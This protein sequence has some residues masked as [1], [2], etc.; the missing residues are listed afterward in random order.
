[1]EKVESVQY[2]AALAITGTWKGTN[3]LKLYEELGWESLSDR[4][5]SN[6]ILQVHKIID[7]KTPSYLH[8]KLPPNRHPF[9]TTVFR[10]I[11][12][13]KD[14]YKKSF[15]PDAISSWNGIITH[16]EYF[17]MRDTL[18]KHLL[19]FFRAKPK[20]IFNLHDPEGLRHIFQLKGKF[21]HFQ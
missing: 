8:A 17:P 16:F 5:Y 18:K 1:M 6:R 4:R 20:S 9:L 12:F 21:G 19:T 11:K 10:D 14:R 7:G 13:N 2:Q 3:K 15:F